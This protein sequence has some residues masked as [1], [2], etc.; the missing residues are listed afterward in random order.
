MKV[1]TLKSSREL[2]DDT[3][4]IS[5]EELKEEKTKKMLKYDSSCFSKKMEN[6]DKNGKV[7]LDTLSQVSNDLKH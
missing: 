5:E 7:N 6:V 4:N 1:Q 2:C 3:E